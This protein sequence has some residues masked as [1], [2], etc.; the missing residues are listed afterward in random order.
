MLQPSQSYSFLSNTQAQRTQLDLK[1]KS[2]TSMFGLKLT[3]KLFWLVPRSL[4]TYLFRYQIPSIS[5]ISLAQSERT[6]VSL[7]PMSL[8]YS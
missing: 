1:K 5:S 3:F 7:A 4:L 8:I 6:A 2:Y